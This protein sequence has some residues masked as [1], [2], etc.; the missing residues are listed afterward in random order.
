MAMSSELKDVSM[1]ISN[2]L[3]RVFGEPYQ[4]SVTFVR[5]F[6]K[7]NLRVYVDY[8]R[9]RDEVNIEGLV[10]IGGVTLTLEDSLNFFHEIEA[11]TDFGTIYRLNSIGNNL[12]IFPIIEAGFR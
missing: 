6:G 4:S 5:R 11:V 9:E 7:K 12:N 3:I 8:E 1:Y 10:P 2:D